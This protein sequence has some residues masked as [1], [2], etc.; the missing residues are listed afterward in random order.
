MVPSQ[1]MGVR[2]C[3]MVWVLAHLYSVAERW[4]S[5]CVVSESPPACPTGVHGHSSP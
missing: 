1:L 4:V 3:G 2:K 5:V